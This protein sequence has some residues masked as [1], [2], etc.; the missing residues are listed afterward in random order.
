MADNTTLNAG[1]GGDIISTD[2]VT[3]LNGAGIATGEKAQRVKVGF[4][5]DGS[6]RDVDAANGLPVSITAGANRIGTTQLTGGATSQTLGLGA[7]VTAYG[8][9]RVTE[10]PKSLFSDPFDGA[11][12]DTTYRW[13]APVVSTMTITQG[14][15]SLAIGT[16]TTISNSAY[17]DSQPTFT[18]LGLNFV[19]FAAAVKFEAQS[20]NLFALNQHRYV[21]FGDRPGAFAAAT[22]LGNAIGFEVFTDGKL[23]C[24]VYSAGVRIFST[25][26]DLLGNTLNSLVTPSNGYVRLGMAIRADTIIWYVNSTEY[27]AAVWS[28]SSSAAFTLPNVQAL[29]IRIHAVNASSG[30]VGASTFVV[31][32]IG[33]GDTGGNSLGISDAQYPWRKV[34]VGKQGGLKVSGASIAPTSGAIA[35]AG[36]GTIGPIDVSEAGNVTFIAKNTVAASPWAGA[37]VIVFEQSD[38]NVSWSPL[39]VVRSDTGAANSTFT[40]AANAANAEIM[41]DAGMEGVNYVRCRV[42]TGPTTNGMT[43]VIQPGGLAFSPAVTMI[44]RKDAGRIPVVFFVESLAGAAA[45]ALITISESINV[46]T[47]VTGTSYSVPAGKTLRLD[48]ISV[49]FVSTSTTA[50]TTKIRLRANAAGAAVIGSP[51]VWS[52]PRIGWPTATFIANETAAYTMSF[53]GGFEFPA[54]TGIG[55]TH[56]EAAA[57]GT[58]DIMVTGFLY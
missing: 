3:T 22:P 38:D 23:Y 26:A 21:G 58:I 48:S 40:L 19:A 16:T 8:S 54:G 4:G 43:V 35:A 12:I 50:N 14:S 24:C 44:D 36:T 7:T 45:E 11:A 2:V 27:P 13:N 57:N 9:L 41:F 47:I 6:L 5:S 53:P 17:I 42:T 49:S 51:I 30:T 37:P 55:F 52:C 31:S 29:P 18:S 28:V 20:A 1:A 10:E 39:Q 32:T 15:G 34:G 33:I 46:A 25:A 56:I